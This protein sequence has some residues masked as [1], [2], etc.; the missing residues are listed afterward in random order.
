MW[1]RRGSPR[2]P[3]HCAVTSRPCGPV[4]PRAVT[5]AAT[6][7][8]RG[9]DADRPLHGRR[10]LLRRLRGRCRS[11][12]GAAARFARAQPSPTTPPRHGS[13]TTSF[14]A[15]SWKSSLPR[16]ARSTRSVATCMRSTPVA[17]SGRRSTSTRRTS[18]VARS[19]RA[20]WRSRPRSR[21]RS[22]PVH[23]W[24]RPS[25]TSRPTRPAS[26]S[27]PT[28]SRG[29]CRRQATALSPSSAPRTS[30]SRRPS[31]PSSA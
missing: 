6:P 28:R 27:A 15:S 19:S 7:G 9:R 11:R 14:V 26:S 8:R 23:P 21:T 20:W 22:C 5:P 12:R 3:R 2:S 29:G 18:G 17:S 13:P 1:S 30:T 25:P 10:R 4:S 31:A 16:R 24:K